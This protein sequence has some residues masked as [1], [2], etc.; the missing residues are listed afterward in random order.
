MC[1]NFTIIENE[2]LGNVDKFSKN[3]VLAYM[4]L[5]FFAN[6][7]GECF[8]SYSLIAK[9]MRTSQRVA[10]SAIQE[11]VKKGVVKIEN[12]KVNDNTKELTSN[13]YIIAK[14]SDWLSTAKENIEYITT[15]NKKYNSNNETVKN[16]KVVKKKTSSKKKVSKSYVEDMD[17]MNVELLKDS[18][19]K[20]I[21]F[22]KEKELIS[23]LDYSL[24]EQAIKVTLSK[25]NVP[26]WNYF[27]SV[28]DNISQEIKKELE[29]EEHTYNKSTT[30]KNIVCNEDV[31]DQYDDIIKY[32]EGRNA[33]LLSQEN[34]SVKDLKSETTNGEVQLENIEN[35]NT[36]DEEDI[37][38]EWDFK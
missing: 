23:S 7:E 29:K 4:S 27:L 6:Q 5:K 36:S 38:W 37:V 9:Y 21:P 12:R 33:Y 15:K 24:I 32:I 30:D 11:L 14:P 3:E 18:G 28:Y 10:I 20:F 22:K 1:G 16:N 2:I 19:I 31:T 25:A 26:N 35:K 13:R 17:C 8:P 34:S